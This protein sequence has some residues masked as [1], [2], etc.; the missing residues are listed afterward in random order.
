MS[1]TATVKKETYIKCRKC[2]TETYFNTYKKMTPCE[3]GTIS[4]DGCEGYIRISGD[5]EDYV[6]IQK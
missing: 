5:K 3:C 1:S 4:V 2:S 6:M